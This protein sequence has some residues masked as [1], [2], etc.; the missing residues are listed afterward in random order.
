MHKELKK[1]LFIIGNGFDIAHGIPSKYSDFQK[2]IRSLYMMPELTDKSYDAFFPWKYSVPRTGNLLGHFDTNQPYKMIDVLGFLDYCISRSQNQDV[3]FNFYIN[4]DWWSIEEILG[5]L[6]LKEFLPD[7]SDEALM[8]DND[9]EEWL[10]YDI[11]ECFKYLG[12]LAAMWAS[13]IDVSDVPPIEDFARLINCDRLLPINNDFFIT[14]NY[15]PTLEIVYGVENVVHVHGIAGGHVMLGH[16]SNIDVERFCA[17]NSIPQYC[18]HAAETLLEVTCK[19]TEKNASRLSEIVSRQCAGSTDIYSYGFSFAEVDLPYIA[20]VCKALDTKSVTWH[21]LDFDSLERRNQY[22][23]AIR[24][25]G[26]E[27]RFSTYHVKTKTANQKKENPYSSFI[28]SKKRHMGRGR[29]YCEQ[30]ILKYQT[31]NYTPTN[32]DMWLFLPRIVRCCFWL[33]VDSIKR[34]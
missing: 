1:N 27:G 10:I 25:C 5:K 18:R 13:Q 8:G 34:R 23:N 2:Y 4:S 14:F 3:P 33:L 21:L 26:F 11:A 28:K 24:Q 12:K 20:L 31:I 15:T 29:F 17:C 22:I 16:T 7:E 32:L 6:D 19:E 30:I 9:Y